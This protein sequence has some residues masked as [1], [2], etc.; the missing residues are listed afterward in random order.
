[1]L[2]NRSMPSIYDV[3]TWEPLVQLMQAGNGADGP[4]DGHISPGGWS[5]PGPHDD[6]PA[7]QAAVERVLGALT[8]DGLED[9]SFVLDRSALHLIET[10]PAV[11]GLGTVAGSLLLVEGAV[12][13]PWRRLPSPTPGAATSPSADPALV[14]RHLRERLPR[15]R[16]ATEVEI[17]AAEA[18]LGVVLPEELKAVYRVVRASPEDPHE[19]LFEALGLDLL[20]LDGVL[21][22]GAA[23]RPCPWEFAAMEAVIT[24]PDALV[25]GVVGSPGWIA[26]A[27]NG[28]GDFYAIDLTPG[29]RGYRGQVILISHEENIGAAPIAASL[30]DLVVRERAY[31]HPGPSGDETPEVVYVRGGDLSVRPDLEVLVLGSSRV[32][33]F[34]LAPLA[35]LPRLRTLAAAPG[36]L[37]DP[38]E[39]ASLTGLEYLEMDLDDWRVLLDADAVPNGLSAAGVR[40][41]DR[42]LLAVAKLS[43]ELLARWN[44]PLITR[45]TLSV[46]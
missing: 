16:G 13:E 42:D 19:G 11:D 37:A 9:I 7:E 27:G 38:R 18:R 40:A 28:Y 24:R 20:G 32:G 6:W 25:Q 44:R 1:M 45:T 15:V 46:R 36:S 21:V 17:A 26:F 5:I 12:A 22:A 35:G 23:S 8:E 39:V 31:D 33:S 29:P 4:V 41:A 10:G 14:E 43:N 30:T 3:T 34:R 2:D